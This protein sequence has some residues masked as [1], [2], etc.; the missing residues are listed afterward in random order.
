MQPATEGPAAG[1]AGRA[2]DSFESYRAPNASA[3]SRPLAFDQA[4]VRA[5]QD[6]LEIMDQA[7]LIE[8]LARS[9]A[10]AAFRGD[11]SIVRLHLIELRLACVATIKAAKRFYGEVGA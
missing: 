4:A 7:S 9:V 1:D 11:R 10:E 6:Q 3:I 2:G 8:S 5:D